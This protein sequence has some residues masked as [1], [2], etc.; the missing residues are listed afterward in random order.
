MTTDTSLDVLS[1]VAAPSNGT[2]WLGVGHSDLPGH[3]EAGA[4]A[5]RRAV[6]GTDPRLLVVFC[7][8]HRDPAEVL[9]GIREVAG[10]VPLIGCSSGGEIATAGPGQERIVVTAF[11]GTGFTVSTTLATGAGTR[12]REAGQAVA[13]CALGIVDDPNPLLMLLTDGIAQDQ[14][15]IVA[16]VYSVLGAGVPLIGG[17]ACPDPDL[18]DFADFRTFQFY[19]DQVLTDA[20]VGAAIT[21]NGPFGI[22]V[23]HGFRKV[24][25]GMI[26]TRSGNGKVYT[27]DDKPAL[28]SYLD[29][30]GA[31]TV[32]YQDSAALTEFSRT[33]PLGVRRRNG[34][35]VRH[36]GANCSFEDG[37]LGSSG[38]LPE[39]GVL[40]PM[41]GDA[42]SMIASA[43]E[44]WQACLDELGGAT[45]IG[46]LAFDC[47]LRCNVLGDQVPDEVA[48]MTA[49]SGG[50]PIAGF[51]TWGEICRTR[52][53]NGFHHQSLA[54]LAVG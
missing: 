22:A 53:S 10:D 50:L 33:R 29:R 40:W 8:V 48:R 38:E 47:A 36:V 31:P 13:Q 2:R 16:G 46:F 18:V 19:G 49:A 27:L 43:E 39:G 7:S 17:A 41:E 25:D 34:E 15:A 1:D 30:L 6:T 35:E 28:S 3:R 14:E 26:V 11:G 42:A 37:S 45:P 9:A 44:A 4:D 24:G 23:R 5:A 52:G 20:V 54:V 12:P 51:Y 21:S 32:A